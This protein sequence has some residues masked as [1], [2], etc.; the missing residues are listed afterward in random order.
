MYKIAVFSDIHGNLEALEA[1]IKD[2]KKDIYDEVIF[3]GDAI[4]IGPNPSECIDLLRDENV[5]FILGNHELYV[6]NDYNNYELKEERKTHYKWVTSNLDDKQKKYLKQKDLKYIVQV[7][8]Y[9]LVFSH[10]FIK[11]LHNIYPYYKRSVIRNSKITEIIKMVDGD[12]FIYGHEH[13]SSMLKLDNKH[14]VS[15]FSSGLTKDDNTYYTVIE[16][17]SDVIINN[18]VLKYNRNKL[19]KKLNEMNYP[20]I[21]RVRK[22]EFNIYSG[23]KEKKVV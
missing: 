7:N 18:K 9:K 6:I 15:L 5:K 17:D 4:G 13:K 11:D 16:I 10:Y 23:I 21:D 3:L 8:G 20:E 1:I 14:L 12:Y 19:I 2:I 22:E